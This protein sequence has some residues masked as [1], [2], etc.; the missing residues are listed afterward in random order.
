MSPRPT[1]STLYVIVN[2]RVDRGFGVV[3]NRA[4]LIAA[5]TFATMNRIATKA[6]LSQTY[7]AAQREGFG[8]HLTYIGADIPDPGGTGFETVGTRALYGYGDERGRAGSFWITKLSQVEVQK[9]AAD[10]AKP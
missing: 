10:E 8:F 4:V 2:A 5:Q 9:T 6:V 3:P 7:D 1:D